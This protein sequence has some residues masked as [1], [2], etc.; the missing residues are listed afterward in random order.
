MKRIG[1]LTGGGDAPGLNG[2]I[3]GAYFRIKKDLPDVEILGLLEGWRG[4]IE[5]KYTVLKDE[6]VK[7]IHREGGTIIGSSRTNP[8]KNEETVK[9][10]HQ[11]FKELELDALIAIGGEDTLGA[12]NKLA[13]DGF[14]VV[15]APKTIDNDLNVTD[16]TFGFDTAVNIAMDAID[17]LHTTA[18]SH[19]R[20][21][22]V[23]IM[24]R[25]AGWI[26]LW[27]GIAGGA[28]MVLLPEEVTK[29]TEVAEFVKKRKEKGE[30]YTII[31]VSE[32]AILDTGG[33][34]NFV[35]EDAKTD[36]FGHVRLGGIA[37]QL[38]KYIEDTTGIET[39][40]VVLGH[41]QRGGAPTAFDRILS[42]RFGIN[43]GELVLRKEWGKMVALRGTE[44]VAVPLE[45][46]VQEL[47]VV[48]KKVIDELKSIL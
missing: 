17:K 9:K 5:K 28:H 18:K 44:I 46:A 45:E 31:A 19:R 47:K 26:T 33:V 29:I 36:E 23:E 10:V 34:Q 21:M 41:L 27:A 38:A 20:I 48:P 3:M 43:V 2:V 1:I 7:D 24:G 35:F 15:G 32:G 13:K 42:L 39:R 6:D 25:H 8:Y 30:L 4:L 40:Y 11:S 22:V 14:P 12:A 16:Y 37:K